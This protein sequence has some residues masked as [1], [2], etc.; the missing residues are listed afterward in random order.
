MRATERSGGAGSRIKGSSR[1]L[2]S[3]I[4]LAVVTA[5]CSFGSN[6]TNDSGG[7]SETLYIGGIPDQE[8][9][10]LEDRFNGIADHLSRSLDISVEYVPSTDYAALVTAFGSGDIKLGWFGG[11][12][13]VQARLAAP[14]AEAIAQRPIDQEFVSVFIVG[15]DF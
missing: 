9:S 3:I 15:S 8:L 4:A 12:T 6:T 13:G 5:A 10:I 2:A 7:S 11:L 1:G 14:G